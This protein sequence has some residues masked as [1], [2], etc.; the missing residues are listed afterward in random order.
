MDETYRRCHGIVTYTLLLEIVRDRP[1]GEGSQF[2]ILPVGAL[3]PV[4]RI[5]LGVL[6]YLGSQGFAAKVVRLLK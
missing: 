1:A 2:R 3:R 5:L 4:H 6:R